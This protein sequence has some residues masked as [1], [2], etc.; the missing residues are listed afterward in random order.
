MTIERTLAIIKPN[1]VAKNLIGTIY[2]RL[3]SK[4][5]QII[6]AKMQHL[7]RK[8]A[9]EFYGKHKDQ[10][11]FD[12]LIAFMISGPIMLSVLQR[13]NAVQ[14][15]RDL[16]GA[17]DPAYAISGTLRAD[18]ADDITANAIHGSDSRESA[19]REISY[20]FLED[21]IFENRKFNYY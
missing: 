4:D 14:F 17:T 16:M 3:E 21:E 13:D 19:N 11:F 18:Y 2:S 6:A 1:A 5:F 8:K 20:F 15:L 9:Q 10:S 12:K 7:S